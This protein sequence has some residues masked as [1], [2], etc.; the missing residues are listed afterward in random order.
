MKK[1]SHISISVGFLTGLL[2]GYCF[3][4]ANMPSYTPHSD[5][6]QSTGVPITI[7]ENNGIDL[8]PFLLFNITKPEEVSPSPWAK[9]IPLS[10]QELGSLRQIWINGGN[11]WAELISLSSRSL[12]SNNW[13]SKPSEDKQN[14]LLR[15]L[16]HETESLIGKERSRLL[17]FVSF[18][19]MRQLF[20]SKNYIISIEKNQI[21][22]TP[23]SG[24]SIASTLAML[25]KRSIAAALA[26][27]LAP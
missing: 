22:I 4:A 12:G 11:S 14:K 24:P 13:D 6:T 25:D 10:T 16:Q 27:K 21:T 2:I 9:Y 20:K 17:Y 26:Q 18:K 19:D 1:Q 8:A 5:N 3:V 15:E 7:L 23:D